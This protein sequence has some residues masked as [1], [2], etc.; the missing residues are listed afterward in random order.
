MGLMLVLLAVLLI[1]CQPMLPLPP[2]PT[3]TPAPREPAA[4]AAGAFPPPLSAIKEHENPWQIK[5]CLI[6]HREGIGNA[7]KMAHELYTTNCRQCHV[8]SEQTMGY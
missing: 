5:D 6:C 3:P 8:P 1:A 2:P 7:P 4:F